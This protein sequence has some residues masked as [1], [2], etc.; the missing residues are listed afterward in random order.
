MF[1][2]PEL[3]QGIFELSPWDLGIEDY[4]EEKSG[5]GNGNGNG[6]LPNADQDQGQVDVSVLPCPLTFFL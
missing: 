4:N 3:R 6:Q 1:M 5:N 2:T